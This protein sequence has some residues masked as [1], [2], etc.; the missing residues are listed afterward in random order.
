[1]TKDSGEDFWYL[2]RLLLELMVAFLTSEGIPSTEGRAEYGGTNAEDNSGVLKYISIRH[3]G[4]KL[5]ANN[6]INGLTLAGVGSATE[7]EF[8]E[9]FANL[10]DG[11]EWFGGTVSV[12]HACVSFCGDDSYDYDQS[13]DGKGQFW[14]SIQDS[15]SNRAGEWDGSEASDLMPQVSP[16]ISNCTFVGGGDMSINDDNNDALR[17]RDDAAAHVYN[18]INTGFARRAIVIDNDAAQDSWQRFLDG[19]ITFTNNIYDDFAAGNTFSDIV[20]VSNGTDATPLVNHLS[21]NG[22]TIESPML[23]GI[24][25]TNNF[26]LDLR[27]NKGSPALGGAELIRD[28][29][30]F[31]PV[32]YRGAFSN[33]EN[34]L[35]GWTAL[36][37]NEYFGDLVEVATP[38]VRF[39]KDADINAGQDVTWSADTT[40]VLDGYVFVESDATLTINPGTIIKGAASPS[41]GDASSALIISRGGQIF[42]EGTADFPIIFTAEFD[43]IDPPTLTPADKGLWGGLILLG[44]GVV[45]VNGGVS[46]IEGIPSTEGR[47]EYGGDNNDDDSGILRYVSIRHGGDKLEA[48]NEINGLT[49]GGVGR[50]T[51]IDFVEVYANLDDGIEWFGG[52][53]EVKHACV[54]FCGDDSFDYDQS[55]DGKGQFWF[56]LQDDL[57]NRAGEWDGS[58]ASDLQPQVS[59][60]IANCTFIGAGPVS[61]NEDNND[62]LRIRDDAAAHVDNSIFI[63]F[64]RRAIVIDNDA[65]QDSWQRFLDG[66]LTFSNNIYFQFGAGSTFKDITSV[67][68]STNND[69]LVQH[70]EDNANTIE[71]PVLGGISRMMG[72]GQLDP[73]PDKGSPA[74]GGAKLPSDDFFDPVPYR[75]AFSNGE[76]WAEGW[77]ALD[78][79]GFFGDLVEEADA[80]IITVKDEDINAGDDVT[81]TSNNI[82]LLDG[83]VFV[84]DGAILRIAPGTVIKGKASPSGGDASSAL[85]ISRGGQIIADGRADA[86]IIFTAEFDDTTVPNDLGKDD[87]GLWGGLILLGEGVVGVDGGV[88]NIEGI[89]STEGRAEYGGNNNDDNS[90]ILRYVSIRHGGDKLEANNEINGLTLGG[91]GR[92]TTIDFVEVFANLDDGIE[93]FGGAVDVRH[94][95][96][97]FCGDDSYDYDQ[98]WDGRGQFWLTIQDEISNRAGEWDGSE[99]SDLQPQVSPTISNMTLIG[100][101]DETINDDNNDALRIRDDGACHVYNSIMTGFVRRAIAIDNDAA[102]DS[103][104][105]FLD[106]E[107]TFTN[108]VFF[109]FG[110]GTTFKDI[111]TVSNSTN[112]DPLV[113]HLEDNDNVIDDPAIAGISR[114]PD[115]GLDPRINGN[116]AAYGKGQPMDD[117]WF[118]DV[119]YIGAFGSEAN[120]NWAAGWTALEANG[121]FGDLVSAVDDPALS[122]VDER[123]MVYPNPVTNRLT[124]EFET[125]G[126]QE[127]SVWVIDMMGRTVAQAPAETFY[128]G[129]NRTDVDMSQLANGTYMVTL[130]EGGQIIARRVVIKN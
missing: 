54:S 104:Q 113:M 69:P 44:E 40:Y 63:D 11:I 4:S 100:G 130:N 26:G 56:T 79:N 22:N 115:G 67:S 35:E 2:A 59:P 101:G 31:D 18:S 39:V 25:R 96:V 95:A 58:E 128:A 111:T 78:N 57:S 37:V 97:S 53:V 98:S 86:P 85:I 50:G 23:A 24:S 41:T 106:G 108:N 17:I 127:L 102:Q 61:N 70:L 71:D 21:D 114:E 38:N 77:T 43:L 118:E 6:E 72:A 123:M 76:N 92:G 51:E 110:A 3:G 49:L 65:A 129:E 36:D 121:F 120:S 82:Y 80:E 90:G 5:E 46:N 13:W 112:N 14:V 116:G 60:P 84:E 66:D 126:T 125:T 89:P 47:A 88:S 9:I 117:D 10:D 1:M 28:D 94:A 124:V 8:V 15:L 103:W 93:W 87:K 68:N 122:E 91:V 7:I 12:K 48:N 34:W 73:R 75:G 16:I 107:L 109:D 62:A 119:S 32:P 55:W 30:F 83:Y 81:W 99:A 64:A 20:S 45:G 29:N 42:A 33:T 52:A 19:D 74:L 27:P 105:R